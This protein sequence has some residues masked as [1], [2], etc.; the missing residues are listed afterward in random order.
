[1]TTHH[2]PP[3]SRATAC[4]VDSGWNDEAEGTVTWGRNEE[5]GDR[6]MVMDNDMTAGEA[7][8]QQQG[9]RGTWEGGGREGYPHP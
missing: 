4:R 2:L 8:G 9:D 1:M 6:T 7:R 5:M 3:A